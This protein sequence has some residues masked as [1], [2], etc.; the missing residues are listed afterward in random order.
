MSSEAR[1]HPFE[2]LHA[3]DTLGLVL[4]V[5]ETRECLAELRSTGPMG[6]T[7]ETRAIPVDFA[8]D[9]VVGTL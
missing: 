9:W 1:L 5:D 7:A 6:H 2:L 4:R 8:G 3:I